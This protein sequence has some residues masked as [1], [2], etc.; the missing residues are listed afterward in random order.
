MR[1]GKF[2]DSTCW[3]DK[4]SQQQRPQQ[5]HPYRSSTW[6]RKPDALNSFETKTTQVAVFKQTEETRKCN[7]H[8]PHSP[9]FVLCTGRFDFPME[10][11]FLVRRSVS[12]KS[13]S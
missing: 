12:M 1:R 8:E 4:F 11:D 6:W 2:D 9:S 13:L 7:F 3:L 5:E 10:A